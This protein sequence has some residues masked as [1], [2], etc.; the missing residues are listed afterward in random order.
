MMASLE[1]RRGFI[2]KVLGPSIAVFCSEGAKAACA[3]N[4]LGFAELLAPFA[5]VAYQRKP[6][7]EGWGGVRECVWRE[8]G[9]KGRR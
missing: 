4:S 7:A 6:R 9:R 1:E 2:Q 5:E 3:K 8:G